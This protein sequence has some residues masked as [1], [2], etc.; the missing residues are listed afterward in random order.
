MS[1]YIKLAAA[2]DSQLAGAVR[3]A[4]GVGPDTH[5]IVKTQ[6]PEFRR[7]PWD[8]A[9]AAP[10]TDFEALRDLDSNALRELGCSVWSDPDEEGTVL[11]LL[12]GEWYGSIP[13]GTVFESISHCALQFQRGLT[14]HVIRFG[15]LPY[16]LR[17]KESRRS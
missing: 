17:V 7:R 6:T 15:C 5:V 2:K 16:G 13:D 3:R 12:P 8:T 1:R 4:I 14:T 9:P 10:P 11:M